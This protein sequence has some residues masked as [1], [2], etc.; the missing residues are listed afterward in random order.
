LHGAKTL[1][2]STSRTFT[3]GYSGPRRESSLPAP[4]PPPISN[5]EHDDGLV[6][7]S[8]F[9][10]FQRDLAKATALQRLPKRPKSVSEP[11]LSL[12]DRPSAPEGRFKK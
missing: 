1:E 10:V 5:T 11:H 12:I 8:F 2:I 7:G 3:P 6:L 9:F 4:F